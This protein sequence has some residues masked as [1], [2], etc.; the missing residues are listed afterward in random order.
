MQTHSL[1]NQVDIRMTNNHWDS[2][3]LLWQL[4]SMTAMER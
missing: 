1:P 3:F 4:F 2:A